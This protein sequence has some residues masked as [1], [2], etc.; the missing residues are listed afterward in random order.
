MK[1]GIIGPADR[2]LAWEKHLAGHPFVSEIIIAA[3][4]QKIGPV[5]ACLLLSE[6]DANTQQTLAA[7]KKGLHTFLI[8]N[9]PLNLKTAE[10]LYFASNEASVRLQFS[11]WPTLAP[12]SQ[13]IANKIPKP[14]FL[15][16]VREITHSTFLESNSTHK[17]FWIDELAYCL[18]SIN[19]TV[20]QI[21]YNCSRLSGKTIAT[22]ILLQFDNGSTASIYINTAAESDSHRRYISDINYG[23]ET[24]VAAQ[25]IRIMRR[26]NEEPLFFERKK[27]D[28]A[29]AA[30]QAVVKFLKAIRL[31][32]VTLYNGYDLLQLNKTIEKIKAKV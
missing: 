4:L 11:H 24:K 6:T 17:A 30:E 22:H 12:A 1:V 19:S 28:P 14:S 18:K 13:W 16:I 31:K 27:F 7:L 8:S 29:T 21:S 20:F 9:L 25:E 32:K 23:I 15:Q 10:K 26:L 2:A 3:N 5:D